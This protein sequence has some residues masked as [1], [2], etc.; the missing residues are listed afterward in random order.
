MIIE[1]LYPLSRVNLRIPIFYGL[2]YKLSRQD[3]IF[4]L[5]KIYYVKIFNAIHVALW[6]KNPIS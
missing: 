4:N 5:Y 2:D 1:I 3:D 6:N